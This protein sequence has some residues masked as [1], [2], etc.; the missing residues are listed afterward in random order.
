MLARTECPG[1][2]PIALAIA[3]IAFGMT[4]SAQ[5]QRDPYDTMAAA[6]GA[7]A[8][9]DALPGLTLAC[10][11]PLPPLAPTEP[12]TLPAAIDRA[13]CAN[14]RVRQAWSVARLRGAQLGGALAADMPTLVF[15]GQWN[16]AGVSMT[17]D[18]L[19]ALNSKRYREQRNMT[20]AVN[21]VLYD[22]GLRAGNIAVAARTVEAAHESQ[23]ATLLAVMQE[24]GQAF[25]DWWAARGVLDAAAEAE[26]AAKRSVEFAIARQQIGHAT[27]SDRLQAQTAA[28]QSTLDRVQ[29]ESGLATARAILAMLLASQEGQLSEV[30]GIS[31]QRPILRVQDLPALVEAARER[32]PVLRMAAAQLASARAR[33]QVAEANNAP[34]VTL[35][36]GYVRNRQAGSALGQSYTTSAPSIALQLGVPLYDAGAQSYQRHAA[37]S[38]AEASQQALEAAQRQVELDLWK[39]HQELSNQAQKIE[40]GRT[41]IASAEQADRAAEL[42]YRSGAGTL[43][44]LLTARATLASARKQQVQAAAGWRAA[45]LKLLALSAQPLEWE[46]DD[47]S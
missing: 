26:W 2:R 41:L 16:R 47:Q 23:R 10:T 9:Y 6:Q 13:L 1:N 33:I 38:Q 30:P 12:L 42:R 3:L 44:E 31:A 43:L 17:V 46:L 18:D 15:N 27:L 14:P 21:W 32:S 11:D 25:Y 24:T 20:V 29:A 4:F 35:T 5:A 7:L 37:Q 8:H 22:S 40:L 28:A 34:T 45:R 36:T 39:A 19:E